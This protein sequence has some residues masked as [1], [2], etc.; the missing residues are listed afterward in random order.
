MEEN[1]DTAYIRRAVE[2]SDLAALRVALFQATG[3]AELAEFG[4]V[5]TLDD[6]D[7]AR[8]PAG[9]LPRLRT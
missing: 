2:A 3:D 8:R 7:R 5:A 4:P 9:V 6:A 1:I